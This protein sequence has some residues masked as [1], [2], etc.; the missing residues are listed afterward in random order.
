MDGVLQ[1]ML[2]W[3]PLTTLVVEEEDVVETEM[4]LVVAT[5]ASNA[6]KKVTLPENAPM[7]TVK[8]PKAEDQ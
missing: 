4:Q 1:T 3:H 7:T 6:N 5:L 2:T 8:D